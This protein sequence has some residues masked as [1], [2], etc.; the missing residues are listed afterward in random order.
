M[1]IAL[2]KGLGYIGDTYDQPRSPLRVQQLSLIQLCKGCHINQPRRHHHLSPQNVYLFSYTQVWL[3]PGWVP[4]QNQWKT[5]LPRICCRISLHLRLSQFMNK[6]AGDSNPNINTPKISIPYH[7]AK[8]IWKSLKNTINITFWRSSNSPSHDKPFL[9]GGF[10]PFWKIWSSNRSFPQVGVKMKNIWNHH[11]VLWSPHHTLTPSLFI[12]PTCSCTSNRSAYGIK[13]WNIIENHSS[14][15][16]NLLGGT[17]RE[18]PMFFWDNSKITQQNIPPGFPQPPLYEECLSFFG[19]RGGDQTKVTSPSNRKMNG[20]ASVGPWWPS[21][22]GFGSQGPLTKPTTSAVGRMDTGRRCVHWPNWPTDG[23]KPGWMWGW[24][25]F[26][27]FPKKTL[28]KEA[29]PTPNRVSI[30]R[31]PATPR[32]SPI[33]AMEH[34]NPNCQTGPWELL[35]SPSAAT[36]RPHLKS[37]K[38]WTWPC[39]LGIFTGLS[40]P[41]LAP[42]QWY[43]TP[44]WS[45]RIPISSHES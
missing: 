1:A 24:S 40:S 6:I 11:P 13:A 34:W 25:F 4:I 14:T 35:L 16:K 20:T 21:H 28:P 30:D 2:R 44:G 19:G 3:L 41:F 15:Q 8:Y 12:L 36:G 17:H 7:Q 43:K 42:P 5:S 39:G 23:P 9:V 18:G 45:C 26:C 33:P 29:M 32:I 10:N 38:G 31:L 37:C 27:F 22:V